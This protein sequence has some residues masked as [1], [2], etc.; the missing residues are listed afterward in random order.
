[1]FV[2]S[3]A[4][5]GSES[6]TGDVTAGRAGVKRNLARDSLTSGPHKRPTGARL[7]VGGAILTAKGEKPASG[8]SVAP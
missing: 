7:A 1:M 4:R 2:P 3:A 5:R 6:L 8:Q